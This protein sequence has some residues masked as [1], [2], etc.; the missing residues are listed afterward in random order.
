MEGLQGLDLFADADEEDG[1]AG[2]FAHRQRRATPGVAV[3]LGQDH[4]GQRQRLVEGARR[5]DRV[6]AGHTVDDE[7][8]FVGR[9]RPVDG[10]D[11]VHHLGIDV[12]AA[13]RVDD[14]HVVQRASGLGEGPGRDRH[15]RLAGIRGNERRTDLL[16]QPLKLLDRGRPVDVGRDQPD[17]LLVGLHQQAGELRG[18]R[19]L[20]GALQAGEQD[21]DRRLRAQVQSRARLTHGPDQLLVQDLDEHLTRGQ[22]LLDLRTQRALLDAGDER[23]DDRQ[24]N[25]RLEQRHA[26]LAQ[27]V[28]DVVLGQAP[29]PAQGIDRRSQATRQFVEHR[30]STRGDSG[31]GEREV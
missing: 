17:A 14:Q 19:R 25:V 30:T 28:V 11:L 29:A 31:R 4:A 9:H 5:I 27:R 3:G 18:G 6:L 20:A 8:L 22:A 21:D 7:Q 13:G 15:R 10:D 23:L 16:G 2:H 12:Q 26:H 24:C 1:L